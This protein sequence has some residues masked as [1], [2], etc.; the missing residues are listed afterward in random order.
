MGIWE[1]LV[2]PFVAMLRAKIRCRWL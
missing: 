2:Y 1:Q